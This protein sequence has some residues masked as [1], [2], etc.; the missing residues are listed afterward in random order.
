MKMLDTSIGGYK[1]FAKEDCC[2]N[3]YRRILHDI[4]GT[5]IYCDYSDVLAESR[6]K[7]F[8]LRH[9]IEFSIDRA[10]S[11]SHIESEEGINSSYFVQ[12]TNNA[13][14]AFSEKNIK[15]LQDM[16]KRGHHIG[17]HYH[18][19]N[20]EGIDALKADIIFQSK[21]LSQMA[22]LIIDRFSFHR[23]LR[24]HLAANIQI[25]G[26]IN[27][28]SH[29]FF[30]L[31]DDPNSDI[32]VKYIADSNHQWKYG[33]ASK[34]YFSQYDRIQLLV[35]PLSWSENGAGHVENFQDIVKE[36]HDEFVHTVEGEWKI[37]DQLRGRL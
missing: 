36:K 14:N 35:H 3:T 29:Q 30:V 33:L 12:I 7:Y 11:L 18:R 37:F 4:K 25:D 5:G 19:G 34:E 16:Q 13:Y 21:I 28:Y 1:M 31:T 20:V 10:Y 23:P 27:T 32:D 2:Y 15:M 8:V 9:D 26:L 24:E 22:G 17:L 6:K